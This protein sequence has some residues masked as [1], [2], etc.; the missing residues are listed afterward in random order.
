MNML[1]TRILVMGALLVVAGCGRSDSASS[2]M[3]RLV[4]TINEDPNVLH[5]EFTPSVDRLIDLG[6]GAI[7]PMLDMMV[8]GGAV[9]R[10][11]AQTVLAGVTMRM[12]GFVAGQEGWPNEQEHRWYELWL[13]LGNLNYNDSLQRRKE[14]VAL[15]RAWLS[16]RPEAGQ[17]KGH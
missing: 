8:K 11:H 4:A 3:D 12:Y 13:R 1:Y 17:Q 10:R 16:G 9:S 15:W 7:P 2:E 5:S 6:E 14:A